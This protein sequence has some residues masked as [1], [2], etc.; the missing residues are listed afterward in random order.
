MGS[1]RFLSKRKQLWESQAPL[2]ELATGGQESQPVQV[3]DCSHWCHPPLCT[4][5]FHLWLHHEV[6]PWGTFPAHRVTS[7]L[8]S[9]SSARSI[10]KGDH[11]SHCPHNPHRQ[12]KAP[13]RGGKLSKSEKPSTIKQP[14]HP[15]A[16]HQAFCSHSN[17][18]Q[19]GSFALRYEHFTGFFTGK[20]IAY[21]QA[22]PP[23]QHLHPKEWGQPALLGQFNV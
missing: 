9:S 18:L 13:H 5:H 19:K 8:I 10:F 2:S 22:V 21:L 6:R 20:A 3:L 11:P 16:S 7:L 1:Y 14:L 4:T 23:D 17:P 12:P 15:S